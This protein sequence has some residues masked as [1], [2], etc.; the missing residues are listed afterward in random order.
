MKRLTVFLLAAILGFGLLFSPDILQAWSGH[1]RGGFHGG[2][3]GGRFHGGHFGF[4]PFFGFG[5]GFLAGYWLNGYYYTYPYYG[6]C[7]RWVPTAGYHTE[8]RQ[9]PYNGA[10]YAVQ[11]PNGYWQAVPCY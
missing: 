9:D 2:F 1:G 4:A 5:A 6:T 11:V 7:R 10:W 8:N 3:H